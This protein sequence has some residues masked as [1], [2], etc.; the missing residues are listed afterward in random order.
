MIYNNKYNLDIIY[1]FT[2]CTDKMAWLKTIKKIQMV[3]WTNKWVV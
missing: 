3:D 1:L 2:D